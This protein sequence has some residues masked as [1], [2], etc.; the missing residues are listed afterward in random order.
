[1]MNFVTRVLADDADVMAP[2]GSEVRLLAL[3]SKG[4]MAHFELPE[5]ET[6]KAVAHH[7]VEELW[8][9]TAGEGEMW[10]KNGAQEEVTTLHPGVSLSIPAGTHFQFRNTSDEPLEAIGVTMPP[11]PGEAE[12]F[13]VKGKWSDIPE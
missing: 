10:R 12:A 5:G 2:D 3:G 6:S 7:T 4:S 13:D 8:F 11:W 1:M 9:I